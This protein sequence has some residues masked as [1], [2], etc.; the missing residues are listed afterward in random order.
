MDISIIIPFYRRLDQLNQLLTSIK[1][2]LLQLSIGKQVQ[3]IV[4]IDSIENT[5]AEIHQICNVHFQDL[6]FV[7]LLV[8]KNEQNLG[9]AKSRNHALLSARGTYL[10][11]I[12]QD[13][14]IEIDFYPKVFEA[15]A[16]ND[17]VLVNG[18]F[19]PT[20]PKKQYKI[21]YFEPALTFKNLILDDFVR[22]PGQVV[23]K[24]SL[25]QGIKFPE[26]NLY[27]GCDDRFMW[28][29][30]FLHHPE[31]KATYIKQALYVANLHAN[32]FGSDSQQLMA[33]SAEV[34][35]NFSSFNFG[36]NQ[37]FVEENKKVIQ[38]ILGHN[39]S[40]ANRLLFL[41]YKYRLNRTVRYL[42]KL[43]KK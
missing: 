43:A 13:D 6:P 42:I 10:H 32:N 25:A 17:F 31:I 15:L 34:W 8:L 29:L 11:F 39:K 28:V 1:K 18:F 37:K 4:V 2:S 22:S 19:R 41:K 23:F 35:A 24:R 38:F 9:V 20:N 21:F 40:L 33:C 12:D 3:L 5:T 30:L 14:E 26:T 16:L 36:S 7:H 27:R